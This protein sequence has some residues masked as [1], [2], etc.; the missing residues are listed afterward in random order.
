[1]EPKGEERKEGKGIQSRKTTYSGIA[2]G[3]FKKTL[4]E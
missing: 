2:D 4:V 1:M 3:N